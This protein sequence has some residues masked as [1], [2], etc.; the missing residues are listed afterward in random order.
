[1]QGLP[2]NHAWSRWDQI[3][4]C[5]F[6]KGDMTRTY[7]MFCCG[8][9]FTIDI[10]ELP[11]ALEHPLI[12]F[13][14]GYLILMESDFASQWASTNYPDKKDHPAPPSF[15]VATLRQRAGELMTIP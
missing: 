14:L 12:F 5:M 9:G 13:A 7:A 15:S 3:N 1:M 6:E 4:Y 2:R 10:R 11:D 8:E